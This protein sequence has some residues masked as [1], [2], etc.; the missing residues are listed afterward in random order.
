MS[1][2]DSKPVLI[3]IMTTCQTYWINNDLI[4][5]R[6][7]IYTYTYH[8]AFMRINSLKFKTYR[9]PYVSAGWVIIGSGNGL[10]FFRHQA[11][12]WTNVYFCQLDPCEHTSVW[13]ESKIKI[14]T[15]LPIKCLKLKV[16]PTYDHPRVSKTILNNT[17]YR[18]TSKPSQYSWYG[19][20]KNIIHNHNKTKAI[21]LISWD[22]QCARNILRDWRE[23]AILDRHVHSCMKWRH[24]Y[25]ERVFKIPKTNLPSL[26]KQQML[27]FWFLYHMC[28]ELFWEDI[29]IYIC[30]LYHFIAE[31]YSAIGDTESHFLWRHSQLRLKF[32]EISLHFES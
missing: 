7:Y 26:V 11:N 2:S 5:L 4:H 20:T 14:Q 27:S 1:S 23:T 10:L 8:S 13:F 15:Y 9:S 24:I 18:I 21:L 19:M 22:T 30:I 6:I 3:W 28:A 25:V 31:N 16:S 32:R 29:E 12:T 17:G